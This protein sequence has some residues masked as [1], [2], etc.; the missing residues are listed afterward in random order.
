[1]QGRGQ[2]PSPRGRWCWDF[3]CDF[4]IPSVFDASQLRV[5]SKVHLCVQRTPEA[6]RLAFP[7]GGICLRLAGD[8]P[9]QARAA[10]GGPVMQST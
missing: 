10:G 3:S 8:A 6:A 7:A 9:P 1:M 5:G 4:L 2:L